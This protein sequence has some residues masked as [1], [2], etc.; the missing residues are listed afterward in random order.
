MKK[1]TIVLA[2]GGTGGHVFPAQKLS[3]ELL[4]RKY[5]VA[6]ITDDRGNRY[7]N[8]FDKSINIHIVRAKT[9]KKGAFSKIG[10]IFN[11]LCGFFYALKILMRMKPSAV[12]CFGGY[13]SFPTTLA[14]SFLK[15]PIIIHEQNALLGRTNRFI[16]PFANKLATSFSKVEKIAKVYKKK[17]VFTGNSIRE[18]FEKIHNN[19]YCYDGKL[20]IL[21][22]GGSQGA[23]VFSDVIPDAIKKLSRKEKDSIRIVQQV[24]EADVKEVQNKYAKMKVDAEISPFI[25]DMAGN[26]KKTNLFIGRSGS[27]TINELMIVGRASILVPL[28]ISMEDH[29]AVNASILADAGASFFMRENVFTADTLSEKLSYFLKNPDVLKVAGA[30]AKKIAILGASSKLADVVEAEIKK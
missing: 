20:N 12:V 1:K 22:T 5:N 8:N 2:S 10:T 18:E 19:R 13:A 26:L 29:Q 4:K 30:N 15:I 3:E 6:L 24:V 25:K 21:V 16:L 11:I 9:F 28:P 23:K 14:A 27:S 7:A 17:V